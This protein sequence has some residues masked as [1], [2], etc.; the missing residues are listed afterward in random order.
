MKP[1]GNN[2]DHIWKKEM[3][4]KNGRKEEGLDKGKAS[5]EAKPIIIIIIEGLE[6][7]MY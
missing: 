5:M 7:T 4:N 2:W 1:W 6:K 3:G